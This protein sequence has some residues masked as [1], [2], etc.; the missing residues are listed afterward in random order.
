MNLI[1]KCNSNA[2]YSIKTG[3]KNKLTMNLDRVYGLTI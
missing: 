1:F 3:K 2:K